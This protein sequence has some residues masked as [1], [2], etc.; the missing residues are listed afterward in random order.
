VLVFRTHLN[1]LTTHPGDHMTTLT[2][3]SA[4]KPFINPHINIIQR[5]AIQSWLHL[6]DE[7]EVILVGDEDG[8]AEVASEYRVKLLPEVERNDWGT[9]LVSSIFA[10]AR[11]TS[12]ASLLCYVNADILLMPTLVEVA[13]KVAAQT[14][15]FLVVGQRWDLEVTSLLDFPP[16][17]DARLWADAQTRGALHAP[18]GSDYFIFPR[19]IFTDMPSFAIGRAGWDNWMIFQARQNHWPVIDATHDLMVIHQS[20][21]Y[22]H[23]PGGVPHYDLEETKIN[24]QLGGGMHHMYMTLDSSHELIA[25]QLRPARLTRDRLL[26]MLERRLHPGVEAGW[27][28][29]LSR[30]FRRMRRGLI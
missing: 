24:A 7:V 10:L 25:G 9:P 12:N 15:E 8:L 23:L 1:Y 27:R 17:W 16:G 2:I 4:P 26:R 29:K 18:S 21:D 22:S 13:R 11:N 30:R 19:Q 6:C 3:F 14:E 5:N 28:W 20:H